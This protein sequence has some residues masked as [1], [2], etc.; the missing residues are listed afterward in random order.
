LSQTNK[1]TNKQTKENTINSS[2]GNISPLEPSY[3]IT[4]GPECSNLAEAQEKDLKTN[5]DDYS[6]LST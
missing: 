3:P 1:Q 6:W 4:A 2:Q 5:C